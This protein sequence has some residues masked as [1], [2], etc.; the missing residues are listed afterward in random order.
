MS[1]AGTPDM[2]VETDEVTGSFDLEV[3][4]PDAGTVSV[5]G[6]ATQGSGF[7]SCKNVA[8]LVFA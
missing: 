7:V 6:G 2:I 1:G 4:F 8:D 5:V 3:T